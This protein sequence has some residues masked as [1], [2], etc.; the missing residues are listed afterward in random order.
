MQNLAALWSRLDAR[1]RLIVAAATLGVFVAVGLLARSATAPEMALLYAGLGVEEAGEVAAALDAKGVAFEV[2]GDAI[3]V[4]ADARDRERLALAADGLP[5]AGGAGYELL[6]GLSGFGTTAQMF[7]AA[8]W[9]AKEGELA[10]TILASPGIAAA[11]VH[12]AVG[13]GTAFRRGDKPTA[14]VTVTA[15]SGG[16]SAEQAQA[17]R[18]LVAAAVPGLAAAD[19][20]VIDGEG[21]VAP[22]DEP[23]ADARAEALAARAERLL[24]AR[25]GAGR[26]IV[27]VAIETVTESE[28]ITERRIDPESRTAIATESSETTSREV[29]SAGAVTVASNLPEGDAAAGEGPES[30]GSESRTTTNYELSETSRE[31]VR[32]PGAVRRL[33]VAVLVAD[34][35]PAEG[36]APAPRDPAE[37]A[38]LGEL[39]AAA[40][41]VDPARGDVLTVKSMTFLPPDAAGTEA[42][43]ATAWPWGTL[44]RVGILGLVALALGLFV[45]RPALLRPPAPEPE[46]LPPAD[47]RQALAAPGPGG[48]A[49]AVARL[50]ELIALRQAET[51]R[52][53][54]SWVDDPAAKA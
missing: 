54:E 33:T 14:A 17:L 52:I 38:A 2:R 12:I 32:Q 46:L 42:A 29:G 9:R 30:E 48:Q 43:V 28:A 47:P 8:Y 50:R 21:L 11:R 40:V 3:W 20:A 23:P 27:E 45:L 44:V 1:R 25:V 34:P 13:Q 24:E 18:H 22:E 53:L 37:L 16:L 6:D 51:A 10:R 39:V 15:R 26:A 36:A 4:A 7:D 49:E 5:R 31:V 41:G 19:V 35:E